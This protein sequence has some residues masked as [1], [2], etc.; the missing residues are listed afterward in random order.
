LEQWTAKSGL[1]QAHIELDDPP[2]PL[3]LPEEYEDLGT[4][5]EKIIAK[6]GAAR[7]SS[8]PRL[9][10]AGWVGY[11]LAEVLP[12]ELDVKQR[13]L[14]SRDPLAALSEVKIFLQSRQVVL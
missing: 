2:T 11:R 1:V 14:E 3:P 12:L 10:L 8:P 5:L 4:L 9:D 6:I 13:L 7:F